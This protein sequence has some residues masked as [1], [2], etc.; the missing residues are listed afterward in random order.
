MT[1]L[2]VLKKLINGCEITIV[3][4]Q[5]FVNKWKADEEE[6]DFT[7]ADFLENNRFIE[8]DSG[9]WDDG[10]HHYFINDSCRD[11]PKLGRI[12]KLLEMV[13]QKM[14]GGAI[15]YLRFYGNYLLLEKMLKRLLVNEGRRVKLKKL[16]RL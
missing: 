7:F 15:T 10:E 3:G 16:S 6:F 1:E 5:A 14:D 11:I 2:D 12:N 4:N 9:N 13:Q 8:L